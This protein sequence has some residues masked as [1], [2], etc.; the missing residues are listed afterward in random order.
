MMSIFETYYLPLKN[1]LIPCLPGLLIS[2]LPGLE[3]EG[4]EIYDRVLKFINDLSTTVDT[5]I[6]YRALWKSAVSSPT[7]RCP[8]IIYLDKQLPKDE[9][10]RENL[11]EYLPETQT[12]VKAAI[13]DCLDDPELLTQRATMELLLNHF[14]ISSGY[15][16]T[17][18]FYPLIRVFNLF[19]FRIFEKWDDIAVLVV[20]LVLRK[21]VALNRRLYNWFLGL[22]IYSFFFMFLCFFL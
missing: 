3:E 10:A 12:L 7:V 17:N 18:D 14:P 6:F 21:E 22:S 2:V 20:K 11:E 5:S 1:N 4:S 19:Y 13:K 8:S 15:G 9:G 16:M